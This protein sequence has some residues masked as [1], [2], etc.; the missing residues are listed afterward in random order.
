MCSFV[1]LAMEVLT[2]CKERAEGRENDCWYFQQ[3]S[4]TAAAME[5][6]QACSA[7]LCIYCSK[8]ARV[9]D[10]NVATGGFNEFNC[11]FGSAAHGDEFSHSTIKA[12]EK[13][14]TPVVRHPHAKVELPVGL[15]MEET[16]SDV[17]PTRLY[18]R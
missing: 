14:L 17:S 6:L 18:F 9:L 16:S 15:H 4:T 10:M 5:K 13:A 8:A 1:N 2:K 11:I 12:R 7:Y 3:G